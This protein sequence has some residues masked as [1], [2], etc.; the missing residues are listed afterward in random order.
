MNKNENPW[1]ILIVSNVSGIL[2]LNL[3]ISRYHPDVVSATPV[4][5]LKLETYRW[6]SIKLKIHL[7]C[8]ALISQRARSFCLFI[9]SVH[10]SINSSYFIF[11]FDSVVSILKKLRT[12]FNCRGTKCARMAHAKIKMIKIKFWTEESAVF[13]I[14][15]A[16]PPHRIGPKWWNESTSRI[17]TPNS[18]HCR[19]CECR[20]K[21]MTNRPYCAVHYAASKLFGSTRDGPWLRSFSESATLLNLTPSARRYRNDN[22]ILSI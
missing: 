18:A 21:T 17:A 7:H 4:T 12:S 10:N 20:E 19:W 5:N 2:H 8:D 15:H 3:L 1:W 22:M 16:S 11:N 13:C 6:K 9:H 14:R